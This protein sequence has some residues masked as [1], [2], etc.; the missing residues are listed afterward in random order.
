MELGCGQG[1]A[2]C[3]LKSLFKDK[4]VCGSDISEY[5]IKSICNWEY[6]FKCKID[7]AFP[8]KSYNI[9]LPD[10]SVD[11][12]FCFGAAH[13]FVR[14]RKTLREIHRV[15]NKGAACLYLF[16]PSCSKLFYPLAKN[17]INKLRPNIPEDILISSKMKEIGSELGFNVK[18][19]HDS[20]LRNEQNDTICKHLY[21]EML[22]R[23]KMLQSIL[24]CS[25]DYVFIKL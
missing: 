24:P 1:W 9:P 25:S 23:S 19:F 13:H 21:H 22:N 18:I 6:L 8:C 17:R 15:L 12:I 7:N 14:H 16:E 11:L 20:S 4:Y 2:S 3:L 5:A 10:N